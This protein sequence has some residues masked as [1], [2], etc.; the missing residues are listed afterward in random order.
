ME[1]STF[2]PSLTRVCA[3]PAMAHCDETFPRPCQAVLSL[4]DCTYTT[5]YDTATLASGSS[6]TARS[7]NESCDGLVIVVAAASMP[8]PLA[9]GS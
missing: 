9:S 2:P 3:L 6:G 5:L 8:R 1:R 7:D 4:Y